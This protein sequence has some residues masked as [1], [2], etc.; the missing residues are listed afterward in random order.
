MGKF[1]PLQKIWHSNKLLFFHI[2]LPNYKT[3]NLLVN[4]MVMES[5][6]GLSPDEPRD[7]IWKIK[8]NKMY[9]I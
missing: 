1:L 9:R 8:N 7:Y 5:W 4:G 6:D 3:D 2:Q